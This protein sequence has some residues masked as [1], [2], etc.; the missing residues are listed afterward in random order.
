MCD[1]AFDVLLVIFKIQEF[2]TSCHIIYQPHQWCN[3]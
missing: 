2:L 3:G 1:Y